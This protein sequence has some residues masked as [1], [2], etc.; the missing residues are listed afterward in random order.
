MLLSIVLLATSPAIGQTPTTSPA[1]HYTLRIDSSDLSGYTVSIRIHHAPNH[2]RLAMATH[3]EYDDRFWRYVAGFRTQAPATFSREDSAVWT[4][5]TR[6]GRVTAP[7]DNITTRGDE[8]L[9]T[10]RIQLPPPAP[11]HFSHRPF[12]NRTGGLVGDMHSF[13]YLVE[14]PGAPCQLTL[15]L[16]AG[17]QA[18]T[19]LD[20]TVPAPNAL[21]PAPPLQFLP[22]PAAQLLDAPILVGRL[23]QWHFTVDGTPHEVAWLPAT[24]T[25]DFDSAAL[26]TNIEKIV[27]L[28]KDIFGSFPYKHY[29]FLLED[30]SEGA[31]EHGNSVTIGV[32]AKILASPG[33]DI[34]EEIAHEYFHT[35]NLMHIRPSGYTDLNYGPQQQSPGLWF[36][37]GVTMLYA[38]LIC[39]RTG[40]PVEDSTRITHL[41]SLITRYYSDTGN[42]VL[43]P[44][45]VSLAANVQPGPLGDYDA[46]THLQGELLGNCLDML[47]RDETDGRHSFDDVMR[48]IY[49]HF[50]DKAPFKDTDIETAVT[51][52]CECS[53]AHTFFHE[54]LYEG[55]P[56]DF[57]P[58]LHRLGL[59]LQH[60]QPIATNGQ[61]QPLPDTRV[62]S[63]IRRDETSLRI[64]IT[65]PNS[66]WA[67]AGLHTGDI[68]ANI[69][70][71]PMQNRQDFQAVIATLSIGDTIT[72][73]VKKGAATIPHTVH[74]S[75]YPTPLIRLTEDPA[76]NP[77]QRRLLQ[78][79][80]KSR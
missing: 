16:P 71:R 44:S 26:L 54:Y 37:E 52:V 32:P 7:G 55:Q 66:C 49:R 45:R 61:G 39:R 60:D 68:I 13:M 23:H 72:V 46:S 24:V 78:Q 53:A 73:F 67:L 76:A 9:I 42:M 50:S 17:W 25:L 48:N 63:W 6:G 43:P 36:S 18:S 40:L 62:Y 27:R 14:D 47:I 22:A 4:I 11:F 80:L 29:S 77:K 38:D 1:L 2:F 3:H 5:T 10:Y 70:G 58:F 21:T 64:A 15:E 74:V 41:S 33:S 79:W 65:N 31:L 8:V 51:T 34:Y 75:G 12:L 57:A 69:N 19:G 56:V 35:W 20:P 59:R 30:S 28:T